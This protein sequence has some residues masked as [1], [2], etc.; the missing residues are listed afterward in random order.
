MD[1]LATFVINSD[2]WLKY[3]TYINQEMLN[4]GFIVS[5]VIYSST[6]HSKKIVN[7]YFESLSEVFK[8][9]GQFEKDIDSVDNH[10]FSEVFQSSFKRLN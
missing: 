6:N 3:K 8:K 5:N 4:N 1:A 9:I 10:L 7:H 2:N